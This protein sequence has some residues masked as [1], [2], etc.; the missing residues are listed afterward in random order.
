MTTPRYCAC[1]AL[2]HQGAAVCGECGMR[3]TASPFDKRATETPSAWGAARGNAAPLPGQRPGT[4][5]GSGPG[6]GPGADAADAD[7]IERIDAA[8]AARA[9]ETTAPSSRPTE[10]RPAA[11]APLATAAAQQEPVSTEIELERPL[12]GCRVA[13]LPARALAGAVDTIVSGLAFA[14]LIAGASIVASQGAAGTASL[15][16]IGIGAAL[17]PI[18]AIGMAVLEGERGVTAG[19]GIVGLRTVRERTSRPIR[20]W[21][22]LLRGLLWAIPVVSLASIVMMVVDRRRRGL[23]DRAVGAIVLDARRGRHPLRP[24]MDSFARP[25]DAEFLP[26][27]AVAVGA[28][29]NLL[30]VPGQPWSADQSAVDETSAPPIDAAPSPWAPPRGD[31]FLDPAATTA[32]QEPVHPHASGA[33]P[34]ADPVASAHARV[35]SPPDEETHAAG[36]PGGWPDEA[37]HAAGAPV[38]LPDEATHGAAGVSGIPDEATHTAVPGAAAQLPDESTILRDDTRVRDD[39]LDA[40]RLSPRDWRPRLTVAVD[41]GPACVTSLPVLLGR[42]PDGPPQA[43]RLALAD[44]ERSMSKSHCRLDW[45]EEG[46]VVTD[47][48]STN[49]TEIITPAGARVMIPASQ[50][51]P[52]P[53]GA[54]LMLGDRRIDLEVLR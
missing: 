40:T 36:A 35:P 18:A 25:D 51:T 13:P 22:S 5:V 7:R 43:E 15:V 46:I 41:G 50:P 23:H 4:G 2:L 10:L 12:D 54:A 53:D 49:G 52:V 11:S 21:W 28:H 19:K 29:E 14:P 8:L 47:L 20:W 48:G 37:T 27:G 33:P 30:A 42:A 1:G 34:A 17:G 16:L 32:S 31:A 3:L 45:A 26:T 6:A 24:R 38:G 44:A 39:D 9:P